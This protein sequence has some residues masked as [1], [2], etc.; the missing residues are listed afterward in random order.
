MD[1][2]TCGGECCPLDSY[3]KHW[4]KDVKRMFR[5]FYNLSIQV[6]NKWDWTVSG[7]SIVMEKVQADS[8][9]REAG[10]KARREAQKRAE[11]E[12]DLLRSSSCGKQICHVLDH[13]FALN[14]MFFSRQSRSHYTLDQSDSGT[15]ARIYFCLYGRMAKLDEK[16]AFLEQFIIISIILFYFLEQFYH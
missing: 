9:A 12:K 4:N 3:I 2:I 13:L 5:I 14:Y 16:F 11:A 8:A 7:F 15:N 10:K 1:Q 6:Q